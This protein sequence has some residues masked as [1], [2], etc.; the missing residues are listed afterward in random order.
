[1]ENILN[2][3]RRYVLG[4]FVLVL[5]IVFPTE[6]GVI[7]IITRVIACTILGFYA[8]VPF[9]LTIAIMI[10]DKKYTTEYQAELSPCPQLDAL[11]TYKEFYNVLV[12]IKQHRKHNK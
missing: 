11:P 12:A 3:L 2:I 1:M 9:L 4:I 10:Y 6:F 8:L 7:G 5:L